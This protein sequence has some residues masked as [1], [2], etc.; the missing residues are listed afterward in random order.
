LRRA[1]SAHT[2][3]SSG[4]FLDWL[5]LARAEVRAALNEVARRLDG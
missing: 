3:R 5:G 4:Q 1:A 2:I